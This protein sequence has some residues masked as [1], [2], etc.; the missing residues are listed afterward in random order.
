MPREYGRIVDARGA[1]GCVGAHK[2]SVGERQASRCSHRDQFWGAKRVGSA[3]PRGQPCDAALSFGGT[4]KGP[5]GWTAGSNVMSSGRSNKTG[6]SQ[7]GQQRPRV[8][9][10]RGLL[11]VSADLSGVV[12]AVGVVAPLAVGLLLGYPMLALIA[13]LAVSVAANVLT[14]GLW[15]RE[16]VARKAVAEV[17]ERAYR[18]AIPASGEDVGD[19]QWLYRPGDLSSLRLTNEDLDSALQTAIREA[20]RALAPDAKVW[21]SSLFLLG[22]GRPSLHFQAISEAAAK[23]A[24]IV[25]IEGGSG[26]VASVSRDLRLHRPEHPAEAPWRDDASWRLLVERSWARMRPFEG[27]VSLWGA[28]TASGTVFWIIIYD[29]V[30]AGVKEPSVG[31]E[32]ADGVLVQT[33]GPGSRGQV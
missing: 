2:V 31:F 30:S 29:R 27:T 14:F 26:F 24:S 32:L 28:Y 12:I 6:A 9:A 19:S 5:D 23:A 25:V 16:V 1:A 33:R 8:G 20:S 21:F 7:S 15:R 17:I 4:S 11:A 13:A 3:W 10:L 22:A 18:A